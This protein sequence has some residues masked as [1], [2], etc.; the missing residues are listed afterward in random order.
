MVFK[1]TTGVYKRIYR[2]NSKCVRNKEKYANSQW[3]FF[4]AYRP[5]LKTGMDFTGLV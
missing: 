1:G 4:S 3:I 2:F 5:G